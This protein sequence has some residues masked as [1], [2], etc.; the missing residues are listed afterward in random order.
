MEAYYVVN[1]DQNKLNN[2]AFRAF[3]STYTTGSFTL[4][5]VNFA[6]RHTFGPVMFQWGDQQQQATPTDDGAAYVASRV[7]NNPDGTFRYEYNVYNLDL[8]RG[9]EGLSVALP[10]AANV[11]AVNFRQPRIMDPGFDS[12]VWVG[13]VTPEGDAVRYA[14]PPVSPTAMNWSKPATPGT[15]VKANA[16][17]W[18]NMYTFWFNS[19]LPPR[20]NGQINMTLGGTGTVVGGLLATGSVPRAIA[21]IANGG[22]GVVDANDF[23]AFMNAFAA[24]AT[25]ADIMTGS[26]AG[27]DGTV[28]G[29]DFI[30]FINSFSQG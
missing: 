6:G 3:T 9:I 5:S 17:R 14:A 2:V 13:T 19:D 20:T 23:I 22:D 29:D 30:G 8:D 12:Q 10:V 26:H 24:G 18:G 15:P 7:V 1:G 11:T 25:A 4:N 16:I 27:P 21:D 28:D